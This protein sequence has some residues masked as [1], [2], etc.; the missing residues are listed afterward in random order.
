[1]KIFLHPPDTLKYRVLTKISGSKS[2]SNRLLILQALYP[3]IDILNL[4]NSDD[5][6][7]LIDTLHSDEEIINV[8]HAGTAMRFLTAY[9]AI[10]E[11]RALILTGSKRMQER[12]IGIL[13]NAL[14]D[15]GA[16][17]QYL[18]NEG[19]PPLKIRGREISKNSITINAET[20]SQ[21]ISALLLIAPKL[22]YGLHIKLEGEPVSESYID[23]TLS[24]LEKIGVEIHSDDNEITVF[25]KTEIEDCTLYVESDWSSLSY[26]YSLMALNE[27]DL[28]LGFRN[29]S[30]R[31]FQGDRT[32]AFL[33]EGLGVHTIFEE[34]TQTVI[35]RKNGIPPAESAFFHLADSPD[36]AQ[37]IAVTCLGL[38][39]GCHLTGLQTLKIKE[40][41]RL[42]ALKTELEKLGATVTI[43]E[44][45]LEFEAC[46]SINPGVTI[47][48]YQDHRMA[49]SFA[50]LGLKIPV[51]INDAGVVSK[52]YP[53][54]WQHLER[55]GLAFDVYEN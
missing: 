3:N 2:E 21:F 43:T 25:P 41:N 42:E 11:N 39:M 15:L 27:D 49:M 53:D 16:D 10:S 13:V 30:E 36:L 45:S 50:L 23:L 44:D 22:P 46:E 51:I 5:T 9:F 29:F 19:F 24:L 48:T 7:V 37:T 33:Y 47:E 55:I 35:L 8:G 6:D 20:S 38:G 12:P 54:F 52:S 28:I 26:F 17:I 34:E 31:S 18:K 1:M 4:S 40:T 32:L 14:R